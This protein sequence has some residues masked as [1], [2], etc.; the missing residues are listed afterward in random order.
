MSSAKTDS[1]L[2]HGKDIMRDLIKQNGAEMI[3][4]E[5]YPQAFSFLLS[6][7]N[8]LHSWKT[9]LAF[10]LE[11]NGWNVSASRSTLP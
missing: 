8:F 5:A 3:P 9:W 4:W 2:R 6:E 11:E 1:V 7:D 10:A